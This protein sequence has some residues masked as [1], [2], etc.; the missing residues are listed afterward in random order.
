MLFPSMQELIAKWAPPEEK[1]KFVSA[2]ASSGIG[3]AIDWSLSGIIIENLGWHFAFYMVATAFG[4]F[5]VTWYYTVF[6]SPSRHP[7]I[8]ETE[9]KYILTS[10]NNTVANDRVSC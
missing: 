7:R 10:L 9:R 4:I 3:T 1:G 8:S 6:D 2:I 5:G